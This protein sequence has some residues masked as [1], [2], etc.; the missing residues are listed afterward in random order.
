L[1]SGAHDCG[2]GFVAGALNAEDVGAGHG[3]S[4]SSHE[5]GCGSSEY[6]NDAIKKISATNYGLPD[7]GSPPGFEAFL[8]FVSGGGYHGVDKL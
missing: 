1:L 8:V 6:A 5:K 7:H 3:N 2:G 4:L